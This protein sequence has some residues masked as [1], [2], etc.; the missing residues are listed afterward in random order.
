[1]LRSRITR[2]LTDEFLKQAFS[3]FAIFFEVVSAYGNVGLSLGHPDNLTSLCGHFTVFGKVVIC[4]MMIRGRHRGMPYALDRAINLPSD[5]LATIEKK[6][7]G[8]REEK[9]E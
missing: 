8:G 9:V 5:R 1:M 3:V 7:N 2:F 6:D 4:A